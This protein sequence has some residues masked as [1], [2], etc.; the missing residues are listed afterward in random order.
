[1]NL[2]G[3]DRPFIRRLDSLFTMH[4]D[5]KYF[6]E[7]EDVTRVGLIGNYVHGNEPSHHVPYLYNFT[8][9]PW[10]T[11]ERVREVVNT[12]YRNEPGGLC[13]NDDC[14][15]MSAWYI[16]SVLGFYPV[17]PGTDDYLIGAPGVEQAKITLDGG[18]SLIITARNLSDKNIYVRSVSLNGRKLDQ[19]SLKHSDLVAGGELLF[20]MGSTPSS[21]WRPVN[22]P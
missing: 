15:Q 8:S 6:A 19:L 12:M 10:K 18:T 7:T 1:M 3:G 21:Q 16:F 4:L 14:G 11:Q 22:Q 9:Q 17:C 2:M 20:V 5:D 13:G